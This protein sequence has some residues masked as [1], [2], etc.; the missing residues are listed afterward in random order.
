M[1]A[2]L[3]RRG[4]PQ[5][6]TGPGTAVA[7]MVD[8]HRHLPPAIALTEDVAMVHGWWEAG[9]GW[10]GAEDGEQAKLLAG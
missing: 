4:Q 8:P 3:T 2:Y 7:E 5:A 9:R 10:R 6:P 1:V